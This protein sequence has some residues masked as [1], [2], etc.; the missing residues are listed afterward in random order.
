MKRFAGIVNLLIITLLAYDLAE[1]SW[2]LTLIDPPLDEK[3]I[4]HPIPTPPATRSFNLHGLF[5]Q[6][7]AIPQ[8]QDVPLEAP[9]TTQLNLRLFGILFAEAGPDKARALIRN[10]KDVERAYA[11][12]DIVEE[13]AILRRIQSDQV[14]LERNGQFEALH[15]PKEE[16]IA[17]PTTTPQKQQEVSP[18]TQKL[19]GQLWKNFQE[20]PESILENIRIEPAFAN[21]QFNGV[22]LY[23][24]RDPQFLEQFGVQAGD[25]V[26]SVNGVELTDPLKGM[27]VLGTLGEA[28][29]L[30]F[31]VVRGGTPLSFEFKRAP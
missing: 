30:K 21:G 15:L 3:K 25:T 31:Q 12:G 24:G 10:S 22:Q 16:P 19:I 23:P 14:M 17:N 5:G 20:K 28:K 13:Q 4:T 6:S 1:M 11:I 26:T 27:A 2:K 8:P 29:T 7:V 18:K 9:T